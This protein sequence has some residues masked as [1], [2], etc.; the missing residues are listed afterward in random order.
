[1]R[2]GAVSA[3]ILAPVDPPVPAPTPDPTV[4]P[5]PS[6]AALGLM[7]LVSVLTRR[8]RQA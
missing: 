5:S 7:G 3:P 8:R 4:V 6:A 1:V 2:N